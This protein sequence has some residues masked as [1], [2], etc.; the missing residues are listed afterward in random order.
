VFTKHEVQN[1]EL[2]GTFSMI[3][4]PQLNLYAITDELLFD[5]TRIWLSGQTATLVILN[6]S[7]SSGSSSIDF[8]PNTL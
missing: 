6:G 5:T 2:T 8:F 4:W 3:C 1:K 7:S